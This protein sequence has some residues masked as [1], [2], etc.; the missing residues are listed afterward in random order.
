MPKFDVIK[1]ERKFKSELR[2]RYDELD[3]DLSDDETIARNLDGVKFEDG[4]IYEEFEAFFIKGM[5][6]GY[7]LAERKS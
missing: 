1:L 5:I 7:N 2:Y 6:Y 4:A 3:I